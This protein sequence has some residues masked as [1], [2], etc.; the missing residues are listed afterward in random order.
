MHLLRILR[1]DQSDREVYR[2]AAAPGELAVPGTFMFTFSERNPEDFAG[3]DREA[4]ERGFLGIDSLGWGTLVTV[5]EATPDER[6]YLLDRLG[7]IFVE[8]F[9]APSAAAARE[10]ATE[11]LSFA[12]RLCQRPVNTI[13][14]L[15][16]SLDEHGHVREQFRTHQQKTPWEGERPVVA[17]VPDEDD[18]A[19]S[20]S[21]GR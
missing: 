9:G 20:G 11:E 3:P 19:A 15:Q 14:S 8:H 21:T 13:F 10:Q 1:L 18:P 2:A 16:R 12:E 17:I 4:F 6:E 5:G 7:A